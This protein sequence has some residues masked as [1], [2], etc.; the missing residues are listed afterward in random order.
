MLTSSDEVVSRF[1]EMEN[2]RSYHP[3][4]MGADFPPKISAYRYILW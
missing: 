3:N 4:D 1:R 2:A